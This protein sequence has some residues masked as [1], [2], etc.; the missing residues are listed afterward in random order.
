MYLLISTNVISLTSLGLILKSLQSSFFGLNL[1]LFSGNR[2]PRMK[3][4]RPKSNT[5]MKTDEE[6]NMDVKSKQ[7]Q[8]DRILDKISPSYMDYLVLMDKERWF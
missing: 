1:R 8:T 7:E 4:K 3:V 2:Q 6:Y 5:R